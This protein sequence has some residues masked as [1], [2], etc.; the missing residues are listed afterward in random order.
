M[1]R[2]SRQ[3]LYS[4]VWSEPLNAI[5]LRYNVSAANLVKV[6]R[7]N[8]IPV[9]HQS[10]WLTGRKS[11]LPDI[12]RLPAR[13]LGAVE[14]IEFAGAKRHY[15]G[16]ADMDFRTMELPSPLEF[17]E[18]LV[19]LLA[20]VRVMVGKVSIPINLDR[21]HH[22]VAR[23]LDADNARRKEKAYFPTML[24]ESP[25][26]RRR[27]R[28]LSGICFA[29]ERFHASPSFSG[30]DPDAIGVRV[31]DQHVSFTVDGVSK[32]QRC[33][34]RSQED[35][36]RPASEAMRLEIAR[37]LIGM[38]G[39]PHVWQDKTGDR[40]ERHAAEIVVALLISGEMQYRLHEHRHHEWLVGRKARAIED[41]RLREEQERR[42]AIE[43]RDLA[44]KARVERLLGEATAYRQANE[45]R[46]Y[47]ATVQMLSGGEA[48][49]ISPVEL[50]EWAAWA[51]AQA[52]RIDPI[53][54]RSFLKIPVELTT[55]GV[56]R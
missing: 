36:S 53:L 7:K 32:A 24:F 52:D 3:G 26:E 33:G 1:D 23:L 5:A 38:E 14:M 54:S 6:C 15:R 18:P 35:L 2:I 25:F 46:S 29:L 56:K 47:V 42:E 31:G 41:E 37:Y 30:K 44:E 28:L 10:R 55:N 49:R 19:D 22:L 9:P 11:K 43:R 34:Y 4:L 39:V 20:R 40:I 50:E 16:V 21:P 17:P 48:E 12:P 51:L 13:S 8:S 45:I 27:L